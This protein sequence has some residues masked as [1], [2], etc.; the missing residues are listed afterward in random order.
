M[1]TTSKWSV[2][3]GVGIGIASAAF[4]AGRAFAGGI[5]TSQP[6]V[7][8]GVL[9]NADGTPF[10]ASGH[11]IE[12]K[13]WDS[14]APGGGSQLCDTQSRPLI[15]DASGRF[16]VPLVDGANDCVKAIG[17]HP[18]TYVEIILD[19][20]VIG[21][22]SKLGAVPYAVEA[23][24]AVSADA[25]VTAL[26]STGALDSRIASL[27]SRTAALEAASPGKSGFRAHLDGAVSFQAD[28][29]NTVKFNVEDFD[30]GNEYEA[31]SGTFAPKQP[32]YYFVSCSVVWLIANVAGT[33][34]FLATS[35]LVN[36]AWQSEVSNT[37]DGYYSTRSTQT[38]VKLAAND[39]VT[40]VARQQGVATAPLYV[41]TVPLNQFAAF[42]VSP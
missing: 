41:G 35:I 25:A 40:C 7:Y 8:S 31:A 3:V 13:L 28:A 20:A 30:F 22:R 17:A 21:Q 24:H 5:P 1:K 29:V 37:G 38:L 6:L 15:L 9:Q 32:G 11:S 10:T 14:G 2:V 16:S 36:G 4:L 34:Y 42:R 39:Q 23:N 19:G 26:S 18:D 33:E 12:V 27:E